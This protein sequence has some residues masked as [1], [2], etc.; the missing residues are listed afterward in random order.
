MLELGLGLGYGTFLGVPVAFLTTTPEMG[1]VL[2][3]SKCPFPPA[4][5]LFHPP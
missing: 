1:T 3:V 4:W 5:G 2:Q